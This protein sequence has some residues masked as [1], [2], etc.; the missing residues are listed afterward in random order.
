[1]NKQKIII[2]VIIAVF[3]I[4]GGTMAYFF[5]IQ[6]KN[7]APDNNAVS[8]EKENEVAVR[9]TSL[10]GSVSLNSESQ[11]KTPESKSVQEYSVSPDLESKPYISNK[12]KFQI[13]APKGWKVD[14]SGQLGMDVIFKNKETDKVGSIPFTANI[15]VDTESTAGRDIRQCAETIKKGMP[16]IWPGYQLVEDRSIAISGHPSIIIGGKFA[17][18]SQISKDS[19]NARNL[20]LLVEDGRGTLFTVTATAL[21][22]T[23]NELNNILEASLLTLKID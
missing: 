3:L 2:T 18:K 7:I 16:M 8:K 22:S 19:A 20:Q 5:L 1:M 21:D 11:E 23:W 6:N 17:M 9:D 13:N 4:A 12:G 10:K 14:E 15:T